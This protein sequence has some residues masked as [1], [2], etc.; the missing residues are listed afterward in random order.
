MHGVQHL[1]S[2]ICRSCLSW[3]GCDSFM[4][5]GCATIVHITPSKWRTQRNVTMHLGPFEHVDQTAFA[6]IGE[7]NDANSDTLCHAQFL[8]FE[9]AE[10]CWGRTRCRPTTMMHT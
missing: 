5:P 1:E 7:A 9:E 10:E 6:D 2:M 4:C 8:H 3:I